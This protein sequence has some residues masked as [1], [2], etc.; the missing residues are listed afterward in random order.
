MYV[1][2]I[3]LYILCLYLGMYVLVVIFEILRIYSIYLI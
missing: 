3:N 1:M 2:F